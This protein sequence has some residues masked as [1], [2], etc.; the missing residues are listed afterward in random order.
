MT[1][2]IMKRLEELHDEVDVKKARE[3]IEFF[4]GTMAGHQH[5]ISLHLTKGRLKGT[6][7]RVQGHVHKVDLAVDEQGDILGNSNMTDNHKHR[8]KF[9]VKSINDAYKAKVK[10]EEKGK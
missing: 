3:R 6:S 2:P 5:R 8:V 9:R 10:A 1:E 4:S 7:E